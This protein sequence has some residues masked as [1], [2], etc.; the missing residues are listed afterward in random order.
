MYF[1]NSSTI[2]FWGAIVLIVLIGNF[3]NYK[4]RASKYRLMEKLAEKGLTPSPELMAGIGN[5]NG[6]KNTL[7]GGLVLIM[8]GLATMAFFWAL[9]GGGGMWED[10]GVPILMPVIGL[11][12]LGIGLAL[13]ISRL[14]DKRRDK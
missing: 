4:S 6:H 12:P 14:F 11:F 13:L 5:D 7:T 10:E 1:L 3:F 9:G 8:I 2:I